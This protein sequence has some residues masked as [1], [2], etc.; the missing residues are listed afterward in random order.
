MATLFGGIKI[1]GLTTSYQTCFQ[2][3]TP[4]A[5]GTDGPPMR[6]AVV[7]G[8]GNGIVVQV[9]VKRKSEDTA[10][11]RVLYGADGQDVI[12]T[13]NDQC[14]ERI[15]KIEVKGE[16]AAG[17]AYCNELVLDGG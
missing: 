11:V 4:W 17:N 16:S 2:A 1:T 8:V 6:A 13:C 3:T 12:C 10:D 5:S 7:R 14:F 9:T 15:T